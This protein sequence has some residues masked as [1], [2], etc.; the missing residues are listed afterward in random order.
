MV[1]LPHIHR[2]NFLHTSSSSS[3][4][5]QATIASAK[6]NSAG[7][8]DA[9]E[10]LVEDPN[11]PGKDKEKLEL[12]AHGFLDDDEEAG[13][14]DHEHEDGEGGGKKD[15][16][17]RKGKGQKWLRKFFSED[18]V[19]QVRCQSNCKGREVA[20]EES[21]KGREAGAD[22]LFALSLAFL[23]W[24]YGQWVPFTLFGP[25]L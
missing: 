8:Q 4:D 25:V 10:N 7:L 24:Q 3:S 17:G 9:L 2:P 11:A 19:D 21:E 12:D 22:S 16:K 1:H 14:H 18:T 23:A 13:E 6:E 20:S 5:D 15:G